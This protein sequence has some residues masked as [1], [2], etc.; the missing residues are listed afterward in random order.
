MHEARYNYFNTVTLPQP[1]TMQIH[2]FN[3]KI[4]KYYLI[5]VN[6][7]QLSLISMQWYAYIEKTWNFFNFWGVIFIDQEKIRKN[8]KIKNNVKYNIYNI[9]NYALIIYYT[10]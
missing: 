10:Q 4:Y 6:S 2:L 3:I 1:G 7:S 9:I 8:S 5:F